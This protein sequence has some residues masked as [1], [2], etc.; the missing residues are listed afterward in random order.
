MRV[1]V[2]PSCQEAHLET[3]Q[4]LLFALVGVGNEGLHGDASAYG[5][6]E[7]LFDFNSIEAEDQNANTSSWLFEVPRGWA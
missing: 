3:A 4:V 6:D 7:R 5:I 2:T 1:T